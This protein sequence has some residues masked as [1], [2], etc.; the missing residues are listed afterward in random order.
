MNF[1]KKYL[2]IILGLV[3]LAAIAVFFGP[4]L[5]GKKDLRSSLAEILNTVP[6]NLILNIPPAAARYPGSI[7]LPYQN[8]FLIYSANDSSDTQLIKGTPFEITSK[9]DWS[10]D[11][12]STTSGGL[13]NSVFSNKEHFQLELAITNGRVIELPISLLKQYVDQNPDIKNAI[14]NKKIPVILHRSYEGIVSYQIVAKDSKG[15]ELLAKLEMEAKALQKR[16]AGITISGD[17]AT[18]KKINLKLVSPVIIAFESL[19]VDFVTN[20]LNFEQAEPVLAK[21]NFK[22]LREQ[23]VNNAISDSTLSSPINWALITIASGH[24]KNMPIINVPE[25]I[26]SAQVANTVL[27]S[28]KPVM[29]K[30]LYSTEQKPLSDKDI[31]TFTADLTLQLLEKPLDYLVVYYSGHGLSLPNGELVL[32]QGNLKK[33]FA[34]KSA[35][36]STPQTSSFDDGMLLAETLFNSFELAN[37]PFTLMIDACYPNDEMQQALTRVNMSTIGSDGTGLIYTGDKPIITNEL[38]ELSAVFQR[39][40]NRLSYRTGNDIVVFSSKPGANAVLKP[41]PD[42][43]FDYELAPIALRLARYTQYDLPGD[44]VS[45]G[46][47]IASVADFKSGVG[48]IGLSG[49]IT[50]SKLD[51]IDG[52]L[53]SVF[54]DKKPIED[55]FNKIF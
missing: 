32:L 17:V 43:P 42:A 49:T 40:G 46:Q 23:A 55:Q 27:Q 20:T 50:W 6:N 4:S 53:Q 47:L 44:P 41:N 14:N 12:H 8:R 3:S 10:D 35:Q 26:R 28:Y 21:I 30:N 52:S 16:K 24:Y 13:L 25:V 15:A 36:N 37:V 22:E 1:N 48:E 33:D 9:I 18:T 45:L 11:F 39:I 34:E 54:A 29:V 51:L 31:L 38:S 2:L 19:A 5:F 7:L